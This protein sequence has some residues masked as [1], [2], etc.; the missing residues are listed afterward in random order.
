VLALHGEYDWIM[1]REDHE[2]IAQIVNSNA[3][4]KAEFHEVPG[5]G[6][7]FQ[8]FANWNKAFAWQEETFDPQVL[9]MLKEWFRQHAGN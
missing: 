4:G 2:L 9:E 5:M 1:S 3:P 6:H 8:R 7:V